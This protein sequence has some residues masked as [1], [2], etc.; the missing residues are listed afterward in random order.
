MIS[1]CEMYKAS[2]LKLEITLLTI[3]IINWTKN[4]SLIMMNY[5]STIIVIK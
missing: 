3:F 2:N 4:V 1:I 5:S